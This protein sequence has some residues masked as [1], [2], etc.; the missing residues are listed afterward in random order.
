MDAIK[1]DKAEWNNKLAAYL[2]DYDSRR[3]VGKPVVKK[4]L[5]TYSIEDRRVAEENRRQEELKKRE[6]KKSEDREKFRI[7]QQE[8]RARKDRKNAEYIASLHLNDPLT[9]YADSGWFTVNAEEAAVI[10]RYREPRGICKPGLKIED[11]CPS[12]EI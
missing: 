1:V 5:S 8:T 11:L 2:A 10:E 4:N 12:P 7:L 6:L 3:G 9:V